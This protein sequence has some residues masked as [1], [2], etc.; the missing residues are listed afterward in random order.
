MASPFPTAVL[1]SPSGRWRPCGG[2]LFGAVSLVVALA[3]ALAFV[4]AGCGSTD[5]TSDS[6]END[7]AASA[8]KVC[9]AKFADANGGACD[10]KLSC[11]Y[12]I[13]C[14]PTPQ[15]TR[16]TCVSGRLECVD[17]VGP[18]PVGEVQLC[19][20]SA[21]NDLSEC[22]PSRA[23]AQG[24][25]CPVVGRMCAY[26]GR[27]CPIAPNVPLLDWCKCWSDDT[28]GGYRYECESPLCAPGKD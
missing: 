4:L 26:R 16:C 25:A 6:A 22:P 28:G 2:A 13:A 5:P 11:L 24:K 20:P 7:L 21:A 18:I 8:P 27:A 23:A 17:R 3:F 12:S 9:P 19:A 15:Q 10:A 1:P 14:G